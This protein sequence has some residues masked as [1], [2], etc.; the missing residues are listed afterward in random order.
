MRAAGD[1]AAVIETTSHGL[2]LERVGLDRLRR[3]DPDERHPRAPRVP[4]HV[5][6]VPR[7]QA[8]AVRTA[9]A[10]RDTN[11]AKR[12]PKVGIVNADDPSAGRFIGAAQEA[13]ARVLTYGTDPSA[14]V[15]ATRVEED[16]GHLRI[17]Y[18]GTR[19]RRAPR[20]GAGRPVQRP[21]RPGHRRPG[22]GSRP[23][24]GG[25]P[26]RP[27]IR[28]RGPGP[29]GAVGPRPAVH[30]HRRLRP[31]PGVAPD[32]A[33]P[34]RPGGRGARRRRHRRVRLGRGAGCRQAPADGPHRRRALPSR[35]GHRRGPARRG[36]AGDP[37]RHRGR[38]RGRRRASATATSCSSPTGATAIAAAFERARPGDTVLLAGKGH[39]RSI[40]G[41][42]GP[43]PWDERAEAEAV[44]R[45]MGYG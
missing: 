34:P 30:G 44:L 39:E 40:I 45:S 41:P 17:A 32:G 11:P 25:R 1:V 3:R 13:G 10:C 20:P 28:D 35:R 4:R 9:R 26:R 8:V 36:P 27:G 2:A 33:G 15:R 14:D 23:G 5:G 24:R 29:D 7:R 21:Q 19:W 16:A 18:A 12:W 31:Q 37:G 38:G 43:V 6:G 42:D 22:R